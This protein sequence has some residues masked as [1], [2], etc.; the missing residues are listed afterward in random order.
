MYDLRPGE[1]EYAPFYAGYVKQVPDGN[2]LEL[3]ENQAE[4][5][6]TF[7][8]ALT[9][10]QAMHRYAPGKWS[11]K[12]IAGHLADGERVFTYRAMRI[13]RDDPSPMLGFDEN[14]YVAAA[15]FDE[16]S[17][18]DLAEELWL[19]RAANL[20]L[21]RTFDEAALGRSGVANGSGVTVRA[22]LYIIAGHER[23]HLRVIRE[24][25]LK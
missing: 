12:E 22:L 18:Q 16:R 6:R 15:A 21:F 2:I 25:Y 13:A 11:I 20:K 10:A 3:L 7:L 4:Q 24:R 5:T 17:I 19:V 1:H 8:T 14:A 9:K 23:H